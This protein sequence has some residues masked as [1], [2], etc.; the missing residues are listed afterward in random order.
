MRLLSRAALTGMIAVTISVSVSAASLTGLVKNAQGKPLSDVAVWVELSG[1]KTVKDKPALMDQTRGKFLPHVLVITAGTM[2]DFPNN[3]GMY[4]NVFSYFNGKRFDLG[5]YP[6]GNSKRITFT[7]LGV[8]ELFCNIHAKMHAYIVVV[9]T[10]Y[11]DVTS[12][13]GKF[14]IDD[15]PAGEYKVAFWRAGKKK[16][17]NITVSDDG[18]TSEPVVTFK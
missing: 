2:V 4:H 14:R 15:L 6:P 11:H 7:K 16:V 1:G 3:D 8:H 10:P 12:K 9:E 13:D 17:H 18:K 5:L